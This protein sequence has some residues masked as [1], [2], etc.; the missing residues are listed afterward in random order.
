MPCKVYNL[1]TGPGAITHEP[2]ALEPCWSPVTNRKAYLSIAP[3]DRKIRRTCGLSLPAPCQMKNNCPL[4]HSQ[5]SPR[6]SVS[7]IPSGPLPLLRAGMN[8][9]APKHTDDIQVVLSGTFSSEWLEAPFSHFHHWT[10]SEQSSR[11][12]PTL[13]S[14]KIE[15]A[16]PQSR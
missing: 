13:E 6:I 4:K 5:I 9:Q 14:G 1:S 10:L 11:S 3:P 8:F 7:F 2:V 12:R 15:N 16:S